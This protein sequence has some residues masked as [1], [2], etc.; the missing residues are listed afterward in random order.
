MYW[1]P[2]SYQSNANFA[3]KRCLGSLSKSNYRFMPSFFKKAGEHGQFGIKRA[4][5]SGAKKFL[6]SLNA[7]KVDLVP[8]LL[9]PAGLATMRHRGIELSHFIQ[10][11]GEFFS[12]FRKILA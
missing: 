12:R 1:L 3:E 7:S 5:C 4:K 8:H 2:Q 9:M 11:V 10:G 6:S